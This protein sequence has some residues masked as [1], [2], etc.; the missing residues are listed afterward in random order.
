M[1]NFR[2]GAITSPGPNRICLYCGTRLYK[3][4]SPDSAEKLASHSTHPRSDG[5]GNAPPRA[6]LL[7]FPFHGG[8]LRRGRSPAAR[9][10]L[11]GRWCVGR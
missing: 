10:K 11:S 1:D 9:P 3:C 6:R 7:L 2:Q 4:G 8:L 5:L